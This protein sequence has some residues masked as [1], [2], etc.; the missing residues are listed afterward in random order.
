MNRK[1]FISFS[2]AGFLSF[3][4]SPGVFSIGNNTFKRIGISYPFKKYRPESSLTPVYQVTPDSGFY[5][6]TFFDVCPWSPSGKYLAVT[7][8]PFQGRKPV[9]GDIAEVALVDLENQTIRNIYK[10]KAWS[11]QLGANIQWGADDR[12]LYTNDVINYVAVCVRID[13]ETGE[14]VAYAGPKY[15]V[16]RKGSAVIGSRMELLNAT[17][18]GYGIPDDAS[19]F[20]V[21]ACSESENEDGLWYTSLQDNRKELLFSYGDIRRSIS[22][23]ATYENGVFYFFHSKFNSEANRIMQVVRCLIPGKKGRNS[24]LFTFD[25]SRK[26]IFESVDMDSWEQKGPIGGGNHPNWHPDG[27]H[28]VM[29]LVPAWEGDKMMRFCMFKYDGSE[30]KVLSRNILGSGHPSVEPT[31]R[32]L[33]TDAYPHQEWATSENGEVPIRLIDIKNDREETICRIFTDFAGKAG[34]KNYKVKEGGSH[35]KL[36]PHPAWS[37]DYKKICFNGAPLGNRQVFISDLQN[38]LN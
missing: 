27:E 25:K 8:L 13:I 26:K 4:V 34:L 14:T 3:L 36:D 2:T 35:F 37:R 19:G 24:S 23:K 17:Q 28:I 18:Y 32:Y 31:T 5:M 16:D 21:Y 15:D 38:V 33:I 11:F 29:N 9:L 7:K 1:K 6:H 12:Y 22:E 30:R 20:P 10:T